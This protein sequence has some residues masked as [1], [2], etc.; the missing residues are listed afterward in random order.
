MMD[1]KYT[2]FDLHTLPKK[3]DQ[4]KITFD[5]FLLKLNREIWEYLKSI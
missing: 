2:L 5:K 4:K 3:N 1:D